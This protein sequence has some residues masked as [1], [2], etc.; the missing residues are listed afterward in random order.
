[1]QD[2]L[3]SRSLKEKI[4][5]V[6]RER[7]LSEQSIIRRILEFWCIYPGSNLPLVIQDRLDS[8]SHIVGISPSEVT[9]LIVVK[10][11]ERLDSTGE[12]PALALGIGCNEDGSGSRSGSRSGGG[13]TESEVV[14]RARA[15][16]FAES[17][18]N[19]HLDR[20]IEEE[21]DMPP[22]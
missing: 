14:E 8:V 15:I 10:W 4:F 7:S 22:K 11:F 20:V 6:C 17:F 3:I 9:A 2:E 18:F 19:D 16:H 21:A 1:M 13:R 5:R 12:D